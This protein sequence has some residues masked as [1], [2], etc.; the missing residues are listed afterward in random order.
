MKGST[1][2]ETMMPDGMEFYARTCG[3]TLARA[4]ARSGDAV[5]IAEYLGAPTSSTRQSP[6]SRWRYA[7]QN[8]HDFEDSS[9]PSG[10]DGWTQWKASEPLPG[11]G[12]A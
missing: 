6:S 11:K 10:R 12:T 3:W 4:H 9:R 8:E 1:V 2:V 5:A 7:E